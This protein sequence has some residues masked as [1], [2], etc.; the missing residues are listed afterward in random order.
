MDT[1]AG[2]EMYNRLMWVKFVA[3]GQSATICHLESLDHDQM[4]EFAS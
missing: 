4:I 2:I 3:F 1:I